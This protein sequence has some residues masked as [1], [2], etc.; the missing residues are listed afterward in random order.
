MNVHMYFNGE[1]LGTRLTMKYMQKFA[2]LISNVNAFIG[3]FLGQVHKPDP[4]PYSFRHGKDKGDLNKEM[5]AAQK[6]LLQLEQQTGFAC[7]G[8]EG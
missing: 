8:T 7:A 1:I 6:E 4:Q 5:N 3:L 2:I